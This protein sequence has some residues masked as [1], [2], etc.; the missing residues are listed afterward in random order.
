MEGGL[1]SFV[2]P[3]LS[4]SVGWVRGKAVWICGEYGDIPMSPEMFDSLLREIASLV[5]DKELPVRLQVIATL[6]IF[7]AKKRARKQ[8]HEFLFPIV[9]ECLI[10]LESV[11][12]EYIILTLRFLIRAFGSEMTS[13]MQGLCDAF[14][15]HFLATRLE[16]KQNDNGD[17]EDEEEARKNASQGAAALSSLHSLSY[18]LMSL[19]NEPSIAART[20]PTIGRLVRSV[21]REEEADLEMLDG[22]I[23]VFQKVLYFSK[24]EITED[25]W[26]LYPLVHVSITERGGLDYF[27]KYLAVLDNFI[28][29]GTERFCSSPDL[30]HMTYEMVAK[31]LGSNACSPEDVVAAPMLMES[32]LHQC[33]PYHE[34]LDPFVPQFIDLILA[35][36]RSDDEDRATPRLR[37]ALT[38]VVLDAIYYNPSM[39]LPYLRSIGAWEYYFQTYVAFYR[40]TLWA[41]KAVSLKPLDRKVHVLGLTCFVVYCLDEGVT[42][43]LV[44]PAIE[45]IVKC[46]EENAAAYQQQQAELTEL[47]NKEK[48]NDDGESDPGGD[49]DDDDAEGETYDWGAADDD[50]DDDKVVDENAGYSQWDDDDYSSLLDEVCE[51]TFFIDQM[52]AS[53]TSQRSQR[54]FNEL[55]REYLNARYASLQAAQ[56]TSQSFIAFN[57]VLLLE[58]QE[59]HKAKVA[60]MSSAS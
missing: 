38:N 35:T 43:P 11:N 60:E 34:R 58:A 55:C 24:G 42:L 12:S 19:G 59:E 56:N 31:M 22:V 53:A 41:A 40:D 6:S 50:D 47:R 7:I 20:Q 49:D 51:V 15:Q 23:D 29:N 39:T 32:I 4:S 45:I 52:E 17:D 30:I 13:R 27:S 46:I 16:M 44:Q 14:V 1:T 36:L 26:S 8:L 3:R 37:L 10:L 5:R 33:K 18:L 28:S 54:R 25:M 21:L 48:E 2:I 57:R 9:D